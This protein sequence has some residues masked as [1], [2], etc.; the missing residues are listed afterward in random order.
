MYESLIEFWKSEV[1]FEKRR[2]RNA[3]DLSKALRYLEMYLEAD[4]KAHYIE[5]ADR[6]WRARL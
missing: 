2:G 4:R 3:D 6:K 5:E 1:E